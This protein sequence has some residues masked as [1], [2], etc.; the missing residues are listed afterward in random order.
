MEP[1]S[2]NVLIVQSGIVRLSG[3]REAAD[4]GS[5]GHRFR[6]KCQRLFTEMPRAQ[7]PVRPPQGEA[8]PASV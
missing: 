7:S 3:S 2:E 4:L 6:P 8:F 5:D 1:Q